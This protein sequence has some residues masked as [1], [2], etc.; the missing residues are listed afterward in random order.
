MLYLCYSIKLKPI[1]TILLIALLLAC[2][3][4]STPVAKSYYY[5]LKGD[6]NNS[7]AEEEEDT[8][9]LIGKSFYGNYNVI[10]VGDT[11][12]YMHNQYYKGWDCTGQRD[13]KKPDFLYGLVPDSITKLNLCSL[14]KTL[15]NAEK[16]RSPYNNFGIGLSIVSTVDTLRNPAYA[17]L[18]SYIEN[19][20]LRKVKLIWTQR[21]ATLQESVVLDYKLSNKTYIA[22]S[23][24]WNKSFSLSHLPPPPPLP[25]DHKFSY[26]EITEEPITEIE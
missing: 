26:P 17:V 4:P 5:V 15:A 25:E 2:N 22:D 24:N 6:E 7:Y 21:R 14:G 20:L 8:I 16:V 1:L 3:K 18:K 12:I 9:K 13:R 23:I 10:L 19:A 11:G